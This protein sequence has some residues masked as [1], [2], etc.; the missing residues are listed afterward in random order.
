MKLFLAV[1]LLTVFAQGQAP[2]SIAGRIRIEKATAGTSRFSPAEVVAW[3]GDQIHWYN[4]TAEPHEPGVL[5]KDG[6]FVAFLEEPVAAGAASGVFSSLARIDD[7]KKQIA[8]TI[9]YVCGR[10]RS[11]QGTIQV[12]P[13]P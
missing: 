4:D 11:E 7:S 8:F 9:H 1:L 10:H 12:I 13:A 3:S 5:R 6:S 2:R